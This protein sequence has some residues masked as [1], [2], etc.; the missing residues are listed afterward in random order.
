MHR[1]SS[2]GGGSH[3]D[4]GIENGFLKEGVE[5]GSDRSFLLEGWSQKEA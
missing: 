1:R 5:M 2:E 4:G 3:S